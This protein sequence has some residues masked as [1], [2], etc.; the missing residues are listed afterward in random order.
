MVCEYLLKEC[1]EGRVLGPFPMAA[2]PSV[3]VSRF[4]VI[5][6]SLG[7]W[8]LILDLSSP[9]GSSV[10]DGIDSDFC[11]MRYT[12]IDEAA[13]VIVMAG[14]GSYLAKVDIKQ[15]YRMVPVHPEDRLLLGMAWEGG[16]CSLTLLY[17]SDSGRHR[18]FY[19]SG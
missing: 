6:K 7:K 18:K 17:R 9:E 10:N 19:G 11:S 12:S 5:P 14:T 13:K 2:F 4:G 1:S 15:A 3:Q 8:R 16:P